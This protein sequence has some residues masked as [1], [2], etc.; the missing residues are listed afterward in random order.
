[1]GAL[2][3]KLKLDHF[4]NNSFGNLPTSEG[5]IPLISFGLP[6]PPPP[7]H[8]QSNI[9]KAAI[10]KVYCSAR[11][12]IDTLVTLSSCY[13]IPLLELFKIICD[14]INGQQ[15]IS[16]CFSLFLFLHLGLINWNH[17]V[18]FFN[19]TLPPHSWIF[20]MS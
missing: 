5:L 20:F 8:F 2:F 15:L 16:I 7:A 1:M 12:N 6:P 17:L 3:A 13:V 11:V 4:I 14:V 19:D 9:F 10:Y 18:K